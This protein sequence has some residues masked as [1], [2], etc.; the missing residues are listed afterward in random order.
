MWKRAVLSIG[1]KKTCAYIEQYPG[2]SQQNI[3]TYFS[4]MWGKPISWHFVG[5]I[6]EKIQYQFTTTLT[7]TPVLVVNK[8]WCS[9]MVSLY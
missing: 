9:N 3:G 1:E 5:D 8:V 4:F 6:S 7:L 2:A